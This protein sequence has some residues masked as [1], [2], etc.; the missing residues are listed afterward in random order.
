MERNH[1]VIRGGAEGRERL[2][3]LARVMGPNTLA[4]LNRAGIEAGTVCLDVGC[5]GGDVTLDLAGLVGPDG[6]VVGIDIDDEKLD[7]ARKDAE[8]RQIPNVEFRR[9]DVREVAG[10]ETFDVVYARFLLTHL[11]D[12]AGALTIMYEALRPGGTIVVE[13]IDS[14]GQFCYPDSAAIRRYIELYTSVVRKHGGDPNIG[15]RLPGLLLDAGFDQVQMHVVQPAALEGN[16]KVL[17]AVTMEN[18]AGAVLAE[19]LASKEEIAQLVADLY[20]HARDV[21]MV[22]SSPRIV[23]SWGQR[24]LS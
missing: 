19:N 10:D 17:G 24:P 16:V 3:M 22:M 21:R 23:Q 13:D 1:Y 4:L 2:R 20:D 7:L 8:I 14:S 12:P 15:Q 11:S 18:I 6:R 5:G 9:V